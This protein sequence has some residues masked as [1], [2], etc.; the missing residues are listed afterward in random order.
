MENITYGL[1]TTFDNELH[2]TVAEQYNLGAI[3]STKDFGGT[4]NLNM[5][6]QTTRGVYVARVYRPW[7]KYER[8]TMLQQIKRVLEQ[9]DL[10]AVLP[11]ACKVGKTILSYQG[12]WVE[13]ESFVAHNTVTGTWERYEIAFALLAKLHAC[14]A[15]KLE[16]IA[17]VPPLVANYGVPDVLLAWTLQAE[18]RIRQVLE[19]EDTQLALTLCA[20]TAQLLTQM[21]IWWNKT[22]H[23]LPQ[24]VIHGDYGTGNL[25]FRDEQVVAIL[26]FDFLAMRERIFELAYTLYWMFRR[27]EST[28]PPDKL[29]WPLVNTMLKSYNDHSI[30]PLTSAEV[31]ALPLEMARVPLYWLA[32]AHI[33]PNP[34]QTIVQLGDNVRFARWIVEHSDELACLFLKGGFHL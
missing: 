20:E 1:R 26:D 29:S 21:Q 28:L 23:E 16:H 18:Q 2:N 3:T 19:N 31:Q 11:I 9:N 22:G 34:T 30:Q 14:F 33:L 13:V 5:L 6:L 4:Y 17:I 7:V 32:E 27:I 8:L 25:L 10:P 15:T 24:Q 12:R